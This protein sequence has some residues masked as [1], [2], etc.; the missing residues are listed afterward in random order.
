VGRRIRAGLLGLLAL[1]AG[2]GPVAAQDAPRGEEIVR[3][4]VELTGG[5]AALRGV[6]RVAFRM[7]TQWQR[8]SFRDVPYRDRPSFEAHFDVR[9]YTIPAW[10]NTREFG[11]RRITNIVRDSVA[12]T[13]M[14][15]GFRP[16]SVAYV[17]EREELFAYTPDR[18]LL[19]LLDA[20][21]L[22]ARPDTSLGGEPHRRVR[23]TLSGRFPATVH[24]HAGSGL[25]TL[26]R[27]RAAQPADFGLV[28]WGEMLVEVWYSG[29]RTFGDVA[30]A[31]QWDITRVGEP[32]KRMTVLRADFAPDFAPADS[33]TVTP[34]QRAEYRAS[35]APL[36]M[37]EGRR[38][39]ERTMAE[40]GRAELAPAFGIPAGAVAVGDGWMLLGAGQ[41]PFSWRQAVEALAELDVTPITSVVV[42]EA[43]AANG[44]VRVAAKD[45]L[46]VYVSAASEPFVRTM[47]A[48]AGLSD[49]SVVRVDRETTLGRGDATV[50]LAPVD[51]ADVPGALML[52][53]PAT[54]WIYAP[55]ARDPLD[56]RLVR[57]EARRLGWNAAAD[58]ESARTPSGRE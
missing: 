41:A 23:A 38:I 34:D 50:V 27:F 31:T 22:E 57:A 36:P 4:A 30:I 28:P 16:L 21:D 20:P 3:R 26:L 44:G 42:A 46:P 25:P 35:S 37:H 56:H 17:D 48:E 45:G 52:Y 43:R 2:V 33:F 11:P 49:A 39:E 58:E 19:A 53:R 15:E 1:S 51:L 12:V 10:R 6:E 40:P 8:P 47:L 5:E 9:D 55:D 7:M 18:L 14:G 54:G 29:W 32:Y 24:F 13:D